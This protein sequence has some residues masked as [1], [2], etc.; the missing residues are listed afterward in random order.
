MRRLFIFALW[1]AV[2]ALGQWGG[3]LRFVLYHEPKTFHPALV[4]EASAETIR[5]L[6]GGVLVRVNRVTQELEPELARS[7]RVSRD[8]RT[9]SFRLREGV[10]FS[11]GSPFTADDVAFTMETLMDP[12]LHSPTGDSFR[13][14]E[15]GVKTAVRGPHVIEVTFAAPLPGAVRLFDQVAILSRR[16]ALKERAVLGPFRIVEHKPGATITLAR[17]PHYWK[18]A[19]GR[20]LPYIDSIR[21]DIQQNRETELLRFRRGQIDLISSV[22]A[23]QYERL[24]A[25]RRDWVRDAGPS[26]DSEFLWFNMKAASP[27][28]EYKKAWFR[29]RNFRRAMSHAIRRADLCRVAYRGRARPAAGP[30]PETHRTWYNRALA[31]HAW[32]LKLARRLLAADGFREADGVLRDRQGNAV[33][34]S[35]ITNAGNKA[36]ERMAAMIQQDWAQIGVKLN[37]APLDFN[38]IL[39]RIGKTFRYEACLLGFNNVEADPGGQ[40][41]LWLSSSDNHPW[42]PRQAAPETSWEAEIDRL[43][44]EVAANADP[45]LRKEAFDRVQRIAWEEAPLVYLV[46]K[47]ALAAVS[48]ALRNVQPAFLRPQVL[49]NVERIAIVRPR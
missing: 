33:E 7:W 12:K 30:F 45:R 5:Y 38:S 19:G 22:G 6:T 3:E 34:F 48:P 9:V 4:D 18:T 39:E 35:L 28:P 15:G 41:N 47:D 24:A 32:D 27:L 2:E 8:G 20:R 36:R 14:G 16:S 40:M 44:R 49:W 46:H 42:N 17:N 25:E 37:L 11:D 26:L 23:D 29:S 31:P 1:C 43:M 13:S 10:A 21:I